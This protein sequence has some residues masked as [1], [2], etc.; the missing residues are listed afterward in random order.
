MGVKLSSCF[1]ERPFQDTSRTQVAGNATWWGLSLCE[2]ADFT[3]AAREPVN[4]CQ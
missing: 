1:G 2:M 4:S 3:G